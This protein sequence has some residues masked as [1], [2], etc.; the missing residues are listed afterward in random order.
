LN[1][2]PDDPAPAGVLTDYD[3]WSNINLIFQRDWWAD[4]FAPRLGQPL[5]RDPVGDDRQQVII[6][7]L[8]PHRMSGGH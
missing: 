6:D 7:N 5:F 1:L 4:F 2:N 3:D 8:R